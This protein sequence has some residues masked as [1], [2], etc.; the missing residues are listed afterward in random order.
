MRGFFRIILFYS[1]YKTRE[2]Q[3]L[4]PRADILLALTGQIVL[5]T[6]KTTRKKEIP[7]YKEENPGNVINLA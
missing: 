6:S 4:L 3:I 1:F 2:K 5:W 7:K